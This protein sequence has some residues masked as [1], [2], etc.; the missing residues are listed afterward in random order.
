MPL[1]K[2]VSDA[3]PQVDSA[4]KPGVAEYVHMTESLKPRAYGRE[5]SEYELIKD[6]KIGIAG[7]VQAVI[8]SPIYAQQLVLEQDPQK[9]EQFLKEK[10]LAWVNF[11]REESEK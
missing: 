1:V 8:Q 7:I 4:P 6:R 2:K 3:S 9:A 5:L 11:V 10:V